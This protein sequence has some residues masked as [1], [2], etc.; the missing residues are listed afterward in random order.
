MK[1]NKIF[2][3]LDLKDKKKL[4]LLSFLMALNPIAEL[5]SLALIIPIIGLVVGKSTN[6][7]NLNT[8]IE[9]MGIAEDRLFL[10][11]VSLF[12]VL[13]LLKLIFLLF[14]KW[15][16]IKFVYDFKGKTSSNLWKKYLNQNYIFFF[17]KTIVANFYE[18]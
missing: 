4:L 6:F 12:L 15:F 5:F 11:V 7:L 3:L 16:E 9:N 18:T 14:Y 8:Y 13:Q 10:F 1:F 17:L 2:K